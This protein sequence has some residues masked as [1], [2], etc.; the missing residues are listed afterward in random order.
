MTDAVTRYRGVRAAAVL[1]FG[2]LALLAGADVLALVIADRW[3]TDDGVANAAFWILAAIGLVLLLGLV[4]AVVHLVRQPT[5]LRLD[6]TGYRVGRQAGSTGVR[7]A[8]WS[9]VERVRRD[10]RDGREYV[11]IKLRDG[12]A[13]ELP[14]R[15][16]AAPLR[17]LLAELDDRLNR[18][19]GQRPLT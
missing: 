17:D 10:H 2:G 1:A 11:V 12:R 19:H 4:R 14:V 5:V 15:A 16:V 3:R 8:A 7:A 18:A 13:T 9:E 6:E